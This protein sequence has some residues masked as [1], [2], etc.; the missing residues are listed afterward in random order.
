MSLVGHSL[1]GIYAREI[2]RSAPDLVR[3]VIT[4]G[5]PFAGDLKSNYV[6]P[7]YESVTGT[8][9]AALPPEFMAQLNE[10]PPVPT[11]AIFS[12][13]DGVASWQSCIDHSGP[14]TENI[15]VQSSH[16]GLLHHPFVLYLIADRLAEPEDAW[17]PF[18]R[19]GWRAR[20]YIADPNGSDH[21]PPLGRGDQLH[22]RGDE[23]PPGPHRQPCRVRVERR[24]IRSRTTP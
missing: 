21:H 20:V 13:S 2:A 24:A 16:M 19:T 15:G 4:V 1:G 18:E 10:P 8:R 17:K 6:W 23:R 7:M 11:T 22:H 14:M 12:R 5:S 3:S 9:I